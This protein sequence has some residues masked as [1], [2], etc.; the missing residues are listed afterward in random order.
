MY[1]T[2]PTHLSIYTSI[3]PIFI[4]LAP[5]QLIQTF[6]LHLLVKIP[7]SISRLCT[8]LLTLTFFIHFLHIKIQI[9]LFY[10]H[11]IINSGTNSCSILLSPSTIIH[12]RFCQ[13][14]H[15]HPWL[16]IPLHNIHFFFVPL[17]ILVIFHVTAHKP[18][19]GNLYALHASCLHVCWPH[20]QPGYMI[21][22]PK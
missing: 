13:T 16:L 3:I 22:T 2:L 10:P 5:L 9:P 4:I 12:F 20:L 19:R 21:T 18:F 1:G 6:F 14:P 7:P 11:I 17:L 8:H 15:I